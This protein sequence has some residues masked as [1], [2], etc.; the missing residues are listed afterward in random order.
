MP[1]TSSSSELIQPVIL[2]GGVGS[3]LWP[4]SR[5]LYPKQLLPLVSDRTLLQDTTR[6]VSAADRFTA[7][8]VVCNDEHRFIV[9][10][11]LREIGMEP[12]EIVLEPDG[13][14]T[15]P[16]VA[17]AAFMA[18]REDEGSLLLVLPSDHV[19]TDLEGFYRALDF[20]A[21]AAQGGALVTFGM[22]PSKVE[23]GYGHIQCGESLDDL[24]G[25]YRV[26]R[27]VEKPEAAQAQA[28][29]TEGG[30]YWNSGMFLF[31]AA[32]YLEELER[33]QPEIARACRAAVEG[34]RA[35]LDFFRLDKASFCDAPSISIDYAV[36][37]HT[38][39]AAVVPADMGWS[40]VGSWNELWEL[41]E[42]DGDGNVTLGKII[43]EGVQ[44]SYLRAEGQLLAAIG[45]RDLLIV[46]TEDAVLVAAKDKAQDVKSIVARLKACGS[47]QHHTHLKVFRPW[48]TYQNVDAGEKFQVK[49]LM[50][51]PGAK[52]S[53]Q[54]HEHRAEHW[55]VVSGT[56]RV[57]RGEETFDLKP[58]QSTYIPIGVKHRLEN[59]GIE[60][61]R[62]IE[63]QS[64]DY[65]GEDDIVRFDDVYGRTN[66]EG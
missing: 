37:E 26:A 57:T 3:R 9:A 18:R 27:F 4:L 46:A 43:A 47:E 66:D 55:V 62:V 10:E 12:A 42:K 2:S 34:G 56:A 13:R 5:E 6:R 49:H 54:K 31:S 23:P 15:A 20:A 28:M 21:P 7:P 45:V 22:T 24:E 29:L 32:S 16:A 38:T 17:A 35:D 33:L 41:G 48:G 65:L 19:V 51:K 58:N 14:N 59:P 61:L 25:C 44:D 63:I 39:R 8:F 64:G 52:L 60:P 11:Q 50:V 53:L 1:E 40:D 30:W 36:M